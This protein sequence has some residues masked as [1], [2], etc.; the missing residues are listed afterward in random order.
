MLEQTVVYNLEERKEEE[1]EEEEGRNQTL[2][3]LENVQS[4]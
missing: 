3:T 2:S 1:G 4:G